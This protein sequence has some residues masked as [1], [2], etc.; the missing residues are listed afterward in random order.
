MRTIYVNNKCISTLSTLSFIILSIIEDTQI[1]KN[2][3]VCIHIL[4]FY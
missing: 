2:G 3:G 4:F 1:L